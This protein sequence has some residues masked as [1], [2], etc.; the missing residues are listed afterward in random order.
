MDGGSAVPEAGA[1]IYP[2][3][4]S[5][6]NVDGNVVHEVRAGQSLWQIAITYDVRIDSVKRLNNLSDNN[7]YPGNKLLIE[8]GGDAAHWD[9]N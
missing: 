4:V 5:T 1:V 8:N 9:L 6:P 3:V 7:I 2:V